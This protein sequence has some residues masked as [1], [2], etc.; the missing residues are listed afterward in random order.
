MDSGQFTNKMRYPQNVKDRAPQINLP[1]YKSD[2]S[3]LKFYI[4]EDLQGGPRKV[5]HCKNCKTKIE[6]VSGSSVFSS[7][8]F[9]LKFHLKTHRQQWEEYIA[10][11]ALNTKPDNKTKFE[12]FQRMEYPQV[13][14]EA[15]RDRRWEESKRNRSLT[16][17][18]LV[19]F[20]YVQND[21]FILKIQIV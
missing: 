1:F 6:F 10:L 2:D 8:I 5:A 13:R 15:E 17:K 16:E 20:E 14:S 9:S 4:I 7:Y 12:H 11:V 3:I 19:G 18:N 21:F